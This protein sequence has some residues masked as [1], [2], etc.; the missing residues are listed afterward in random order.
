MPQTLQQYP[1]S[2]CREIFR[3]KRPSLKSKFLY[4]FLSD[5]QNFS[6]KSKLTLEATMSENNMLIGKAIDP[7]NAG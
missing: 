3:K 6:A 5:S 4:H 2:I 7:R 1:Y